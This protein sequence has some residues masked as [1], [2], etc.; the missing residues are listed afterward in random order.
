MTTSSYESLS[1]SR[2]DCKYHVVFV[3]KYRKKAI[4]GQKKEFLRRIFHEL[5]AQ[6]GCEIVSGSLVH[7]HVHML[8]RIP[9]KYAVAEVVGFLKGKS[10]IAIA[11]QF[12]GRKRNFNGESFWTRG[13]SVSTVGYDY[14]SIR[15]Y[16]ENQEQIDKTDSDEVSTF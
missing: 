6:K 13:Y 4:Y 8:I 3:P 5:A 16:I 10:A 1:H 14:E 2:W 11:R 7:D 15:T 12:G 9:P